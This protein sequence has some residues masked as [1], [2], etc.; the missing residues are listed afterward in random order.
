MKTR[1]LD[2]WRG[3]STREQTL[4][5]ICAALAAIVV[6]YVAAFAPALA[7]RSE[8]AQRAIARE[9]E[10]RLVSNAARLSASV[11]S[12]AGADTPVRNALTEIAAQ[13][14]I[15]LVFVNAREDGSVDAQIGSAAPDKLFA[16]IDT[17]ERQYGVRIV[18]ADIAR[19]SDGAETVRAQ[20]TLS[21]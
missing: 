11:T 9:T 18:A 4:L 19:V 17:L 14:G 12:A 8:A 7:W 13:T 20:L 2:W 3:R 5:L 21:R 6:G 10:F 15:E 1:A 16:M